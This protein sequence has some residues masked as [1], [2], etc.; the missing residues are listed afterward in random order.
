VGF[1]KSLEASGLG[2]WVR[3][4]YVGYPSM[5]ASHAVGMAIMVGLSFAFALRVLGLFGE[6]PYL[7]LQRYLVIA[8][9]GFA[10]N[11]ISGSALF[12]AQAADYVIDS[13]FLLKMA[14][15]IAGMTMVAI[16]QTQVRRHAVSWGN[17]P[18]SPATR[19][20]AGLTIFCWVV[21]M[22]FGRLIAYL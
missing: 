6:I 19:V 15:V 7:A 2:D 11:F 4:S 16:N 12:S 22:I 14:F 8:W 21:A 9:I 18:A 10:I 3:T 1:L 17:G 13:T 20:V 5:I